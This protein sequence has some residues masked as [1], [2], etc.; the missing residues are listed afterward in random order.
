MKWFL[1]LSTRAKLFLG[2]GLMVLLLVVMVTTAYDGI[3]TIRESQRRLYELNFADAVDL[4][5][6]RANSNGARLETLEM[7]LTPRRSEQEALERDIKG[8]TR[9]S[10]EIAR[11][12]RQR[13]GG[14]AEVLRQLSELDQLRKVYEEI[15]D[16]KVLPLILQGKVEEAQALGAGLQAE[17]HDRMH[18]ILRRLDEAAI[19]DARTNL[20]E[21]DRRARES[22][23]K[24]GK[25]KPE[26][27][28][29]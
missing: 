17:R 22:A 15:R 26:K 20:A 8:R 4:A 14:D 27:T 29:K 13:N 19:E 28:G 24:A 10:D 11:R 21:S 1:N 9:T 5:L 18:D 2:F 3:A 25:K 16:E 7:M 23:A 6:L 12:L